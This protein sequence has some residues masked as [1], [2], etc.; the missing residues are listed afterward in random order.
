[1]PATAPSVAG[2]S[3]AGLRSASDDDSHGGSGAAGQ[4]IWLC[5]G[6]QLPDPLWAAL[7]GQVPWTDPSEL[8]EPGDLDQPAGGGDAGGSGDGPGSGDADGAG[9]AGSDCPGG[10]GAGG[11]GDAGRG[12]RGGGDDDGADG[13]CGTGGGEVPVVAGFCQGGVLDSLPPGPELGL[14][15][16]SAGD[17]AGLGD[18]ELTGALRGWRRLG[19]W[20]AAMEH[21]A[22]AELATR[23]IGE[24]KTAGAGETEAGRYAAAEIAAALTLTRCSADNLT[25]RALVFAELPATWA[26][27][28]SGRIDMPKALVITTG[29]TGLPARLTRQVEAQ[30]LAKAARQTTGE[31]RKTVAA[32]VIAADPARPGLPQPA[33]RPPRRR[34]RTRTRARTRRSRARPTTRPQPQPRPRPRPRPRGRRFARRQRHPRASSRPQPGR[35]HTP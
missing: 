33:A 23:R 9:D 6:D 7:C 11:G 14:L 25:G 16:P 3:A 27:L 29:I 12:G 34:P 17:V 22:A 8:G 1:M 15:L 35:H 24:A 31:L 2:P 21:A 32:A 19:S 18:G 5:G 4:G 10:G 13:A 20:A 26:A 28:A 30:V